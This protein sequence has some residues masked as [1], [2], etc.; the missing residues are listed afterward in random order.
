M[1]MKKYSLLLALSVLVASVYA[2]PEYEAKKKKMGEGKFE[3]AISYLAIGGDMVYALEAGGK[4]H[5][6]S[7]KSG[8]RKSQ[9]ETGMEN[10]QAIAVNAKGE[11]FVFSTTT[12]QEQRTHGSRKYTVDVPQGVACKVFDKKGKELRTLTFD[13]LKSA[14]AAKFVGDRLV[15][16]DIGERKLVFL[17]PETGKQTAEVKAGLRLCCGIFDFCAGPDDTVAVANLGA[18]KVQQYTLDG[19]P[20]KAF[21]KRGK[22]FDEFQGCCNPVSVGYLPDGRIVTVEKSPTRIKIYDADGKNAA[23]IDGVEELVQG[24]SHIPVAI[25]SEGNVF[26]AASRKGYIVKCIPKS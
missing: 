26:L 19:K 5:A 3:G 17:D 25:D 14:K 8:S 12:K 1:M 13:A 7:A 24:C 11:I 10:T 4:V 6:F 18:F 2:V 16:A 23:Q 22:A 21:G 9:F 20:G 15:V